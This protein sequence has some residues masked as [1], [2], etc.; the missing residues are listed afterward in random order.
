M[1]GSA[2]KALFELQ[3]DVAYSSY[4]DDP[5]LN[6]LVN[7]AFINVTQSIYLNRLNN[8][9]AFDEM[10]YLVAL[11]KTFSVDSAT[12]TL[13]LYSTAQTILG[14]TYTGGTNPTVTITTTLPHDLLVGMSVDLAG[15]AGT[16]TLPAALNGNTYQVVS[17]AATSFTF[18]KSGAALTGVYTASSGNF[19]PHYN[20]T[21]YLHYLFAEVK[22]TQSLSPL[23]VSSSTNAT[24]IKITL[25]K[26][27][28]LRTSEQVVIAGIA[29]NT[30]AN[31]TFYL[32][33]AN[34]YDYYLY[35]DAF[36]QTPI[37]GNGTQ[38]GTGTIS[39]I[40]TSVQKFKKFDQKGNLL[41]APTVQTPYFQE[42]ERFLK[43]YPL[44]Y[45]CSSITMDYI[46]KLPFSIDVTDTTTDLSSY[47]PLSI[48][49]EIVNELV[50]LFAGS[51]R[52]IGLV[53]DAKDQLIQNP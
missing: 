32:R 14:L 37:V 44:T 46:R 45:P 8:Q 9:N 33:Q 39:Q 15:I 3:S 41:G 4:L 53:Q 18:V 43:V 21:D 30:N 25:N 19:I 51:T 12:N 36:L 24:P 7:K 10:N 28:T 52:D 34:D 20:V 38:T 26:R 35:S 17:V 31:G 48:Q 5:K 29:G 16:L 50:R 23:V 22:F 6:E 42:Q 47:F 49:Y 11:D 1:T 27:S 13:F 40:F 2:L